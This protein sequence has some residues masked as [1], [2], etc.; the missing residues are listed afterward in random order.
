[1]EFHARAEGPSVT[2]QRHRD[3]DE[4]VTVHAP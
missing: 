4:R 1:M 3:D 2:H